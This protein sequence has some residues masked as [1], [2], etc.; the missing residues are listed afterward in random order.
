MKNVIVFLSL[1][2]PGVLISSCTSQTA[3]SMQPK[4][5]AENIKSENVVVLDVRTP[6]EYKEGHIKGATL[7]NWQDPEK[8]KEGTSKL[9]KNKPVYVYCKAGVRGEKA[10]DWLTQNG[11]KEVVN[12][13]GGIQSWIDA[14]K[15]VEK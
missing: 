7:A 15:P 12:L 13:E 2:F 14:G 6:E 9:D 4:D 3:P 10:A 5:F 8:F 11:F 1:I